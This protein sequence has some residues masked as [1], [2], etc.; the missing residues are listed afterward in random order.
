MLV[1][2]CVADQRSV[3]VR[4][5]AVAVSGPMVR[6][7]ST[8]KVFA[9]NEPFWLDFSEWPLIVLSRRNP[10]KLNTRVRFPSPAP[11]FFSGFVRIIGFYSDN[12]S[13]RG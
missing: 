9:I 12:Y 5:N 3:T 8:K 2:A 6:S 10:S 13:G 7:E 1:K 4:P 11:V